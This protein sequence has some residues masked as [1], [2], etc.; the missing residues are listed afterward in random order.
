MR[1]R[2]HVSG[3]LA[4][5]IVCFFVSGGVQAQG[6]PLQARVTRLIEQLGDT[7]FDKQDDARQQLE[8]IG[9][10]AR[11][12]LLVAMEKNADREVREQVRSVLKRINAAKVSGL[13]KQLGDDSAKVRQAAEKEL[14]KMIARDSTTDEAM[15]YEAAR[16]RLARVM[17]KHPDKEIRACASRILD[18]EVVPKRIRESI[19]QLGS[20]DEEKRKVAERYLIRIGK[21]AL[22]ALQQTAKDDPDADIRLRATLVLKAINRSGN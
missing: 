19:K 8:K 5:A 22:P 1:D 12:H 6:G 16:E 18:N 13:I 7:D 17:S 2:E 11:E 21:P 14:G 15:Q 10:L 9:E 3:W 4:L 20:D